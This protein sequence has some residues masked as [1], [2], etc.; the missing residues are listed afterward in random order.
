MAKNEDTGMIVF[1]YAR[2]GN[3]DMLDNVDAIR[4]AT[5]L[6]MSAS[7]VIWKNPKPRQ[8]RQHHPSATSVLQN[9]AYLIRSQFAYRLQCSNSRAI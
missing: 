7:G 3:N 1:T 2:A 9:L 6:R 4:N 5:S 8:N